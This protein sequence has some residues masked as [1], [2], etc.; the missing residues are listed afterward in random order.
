MLEQGKI[1]RNQVSYDS[2]DQSEWGALAEDSRHTM[3]D[4]E[5]VALV[6]QQTH[7]SMVEESSPKEEEL[8]RKTGDADCYRIYL[9]TLGWGFV[10]FMFCLQI[11]STGLEVMPRRSLPPSHQYRCA[12]QI[13]IGIWLRLW[14]EKGNGS[15]DPGYTGG[16]VAFATSSMFLSAFTLG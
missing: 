7:A 3:N 16:Y 4:E 15:R 2:C 8:A 9:E 6:K 13:S 12:N 1:V 14:T 11:V 10:L 5:G